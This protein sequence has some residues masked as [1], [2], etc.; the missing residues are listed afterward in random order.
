TPVFRR[1]C[2]QIKELELGF[3]SIKAGKALGPS[4]LYRLQ[5]FEGQ[6]LRIS[7]AGQIKLANECCDRVAITVGQGHDGVDG[8]TLSVHGL[9]V[10][11]AASDPAAY[12]PPVNSPLTV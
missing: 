1:K 8:D 9:L 12:E 11:T 10:L 4:G 7:H 3:D 6:A 5:T 2:D